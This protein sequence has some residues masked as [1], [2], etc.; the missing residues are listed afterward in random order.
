M[1]PAV[2]FLFLAVLLLPVSTSAQVSTATVNGTIADESKLVLP[3]VTVTATDLETGRQYVAVSDERGVY[4]LVNM[5]PGAYKIQ[6]EL[7]GFAT[8]EIPH[9]ELLVGQN[10]TL[11]F[12]MKL[13]TIAETLTVISE[14]PLVDV[15]SSQVAGYIDRRQMDAVPV[16][17]RNWME[18]S[19]LVKGITTNNA[20][21]TPGT[22][23]DAFQLNLDGQQIKQNA[24]GAGSGQPRFSRE[25]IAEFQ[26]V[27]N[28]FDVTQGRSTGVQVHAISRSGTNNLSGVVYGYFRDDKLNAPDPVANRVLPYSNQQIGGVLGG[29]IVKDKLHYFFSYE[30]ENQPFTNFTQ[31]AFLGGPS[32]SKESKTRHHSYLGRVDWHSSPRNSVS[33]RAPVSTPR[34]RFSYPAAPIPP[35]QR[36]ARTTAPISSAPGTVS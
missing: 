19:M 25:A 5:P 24:I 28:L 12:V 33:F 30:N 11:G 22:H 3:G 10:A 2:T 34:R 29:P 36:R 16:Q 6:A 17:G 13:A 26:I 4:R 21:N 35:G 8:A 20:T 27:T 32:F 31:P 7:G 1:R 18:L 14:A 9:V 23:G 15:R